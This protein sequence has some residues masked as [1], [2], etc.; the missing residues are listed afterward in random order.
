MKMVWRQFESV[1]DINF[2]EWLYHND[3]EC[4]VETDDS[5]R[6][7]VKV[8]QLKIYPTDYFIVEDNGIISVR[9]EEDFKRDYGYAL[10][11]IGVVRDV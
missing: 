5:N 1:D 4:S 3:I 7:Y 8:G 2:M 9:N 11:E 6:K 10:G